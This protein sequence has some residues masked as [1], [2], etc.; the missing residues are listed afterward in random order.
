MQYNALCRLFKT[1]TTIQG[2]MDLI[3]LDSDKSF[4]D[5]V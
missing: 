1:N 2:M 4:E 3:K 5:L